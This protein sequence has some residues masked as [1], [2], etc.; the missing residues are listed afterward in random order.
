MN[1]V[2][3]VF[4]LVTLHCC[5]SFGAKSI[6]HKKKFFFAPRIDCNQV[7]LII[8]FMLLKCYVPYIR[9]FRVCRL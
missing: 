4:C 7:V 6:L 5:Y 1:K 3:V 2:I 8:R 9:Q